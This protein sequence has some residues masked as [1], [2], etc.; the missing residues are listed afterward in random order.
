MVR[1][2]I[3]NLSPLVL[4][5]V[6]A[7]VIIIILGIVAFFIFRS[8]VVKLDDDEHMQ[9]EFAAIDREAQFASAAEQTGYHKDPDELA[10]SI[11]VL[12]RDFLSMPVIGIYAGREGRA[13]GT[14][15]A[16]IEH[17]GPLTTPSHAIALQV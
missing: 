17:L 6:V 4:V 2:Q 3:N 16:D 7:G 13:I 14:V 15:A 11:S 10:R 12:F 5:L 9:A 1:D 8:R